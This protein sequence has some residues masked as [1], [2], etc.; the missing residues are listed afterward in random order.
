MVGVWVLITIGMLC[1]F[2][3]LVKN[4]GSQASIT[5]VA[6]LAFAMIIERTSHRFFQL[7]K[8]QTKQTLP[9]D[10]DDDAL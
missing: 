10:T 1:C 9:V 7:K 6:I 2:D 8:L 4:M 3:W 5:L